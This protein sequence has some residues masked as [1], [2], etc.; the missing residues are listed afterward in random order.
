M[1]KTK[2]AKKTKDENL[3]DEEYAKRLRLEFEKEY[4]ENG[5]EPDVAEKVAQITVDL[6][7]AADSE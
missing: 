7:L 2:D 1:A 3:S 6:L 4:L 5:I